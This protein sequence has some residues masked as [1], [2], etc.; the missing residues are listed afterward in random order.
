MQK[1]PNYLGTIVVKIG[2]SPLGEH[3][4][5]LHALVALQKEG[6][7][8]VDDETRYTSQ[9]QRRSEGDRQG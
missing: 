7:S 9:V 8:P 1:E 3:D 5:T 4:T 2:G 6:A